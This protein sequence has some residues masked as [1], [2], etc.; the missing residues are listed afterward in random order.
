MW[1]KVQPMG[2][3]KIKDMIKGIVADTLLE[4]SHKKFTNHSASKTVEQ[5]EESECQAVRDFKGH[6]TQEH[7]VIKRLRRVK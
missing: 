3:S 6:R 4:C 1:F 7:P 5:V 2:E